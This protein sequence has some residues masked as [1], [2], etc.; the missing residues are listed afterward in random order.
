MTDPI[1][2]KMAFIEIF[3]E[4]LK[5]DAFVFYQYLHQ[6][7]LAISLVQDN[8]KE[9]NNS[10]TF[11]KTQTSDS[12]LWDFNNPSFHWRTQRKLIRLI[13]NY[14]S[15]V[16][17]LVNYTRKSIEPYIKLNGAINE[18]YENLKHAQFSSNSQHR[19]IQDLRNFT[20]H[21]SHLKIASEYSTNIAW[22]EPKRNIFV[23]KEELLQSTEW[24]VQSKQFIDTLGEKIYISDIIN[25]HYSKFIKFQKE[26]YSMTLLVDETRTKFFIQSVTTLLEQSKEYESSGILT[27]NLAYIRYLNYLLKAALRTTGVL[28]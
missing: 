21:D 27:F 15:S 10:M 3:R 18:A 12:R 24:S 11:L 2:K 26:I 23:K 28:R 16:F 5:S 13:A 14:L 4:Y 25:E 17:N 9:L 8:F 1:T 19:F 6:N 7:R 20:T 22:D